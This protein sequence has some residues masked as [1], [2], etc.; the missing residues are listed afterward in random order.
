M[1]RPHIWSAAGVIN[2][3]HGMGEDVEISVKRLR[4][5]RDSVCRLHERLWAFA[6]LV[7]ACWILSHPR[8]GYPPAGLHTIERA[9]LYPERRKFLSALA[10]PA[11]SISLLI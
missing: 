1:E 7:K 8:H 6:A 5:F 10:S 11:R 3:I 2:L 4:D 9:C